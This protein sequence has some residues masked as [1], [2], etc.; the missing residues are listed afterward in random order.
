MAFLSLSGFRKNNKWG[1]LRRVLTLSNVRPVVTFL[2][3]NF[4]FSTTYSSNSSEKHNHHTDRNQSG[5]EVLISPFH[6][7]CTHILPTWCTL[8]CDTLHVFS[9]QKFVSSDSSP[10][11]VLV[12]HGPTTR[13]LFKWAVRA[14]RKSTWGDDGRLVSYFT[15]TE[16]TIISSQFLLPKQ[17]L[18]FGEIS[19]CKHK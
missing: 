9:L 11:G 15:K 16:I 18:H 7:Y 14:K 4:H 12:G 1:C 5:Y 2:S 13:I 8:Q 10:G 19:Y 6:K 17:E 3:F